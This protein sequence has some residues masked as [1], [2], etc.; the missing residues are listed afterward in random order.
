[1]AGLL[2]EA[3]GLGE[4]VGDDVG[5]GLVVGEAPQ[6]GVVGDGSEAEGVAEAVGEL[7][8]LLRRA[9]VEAEVLLEQKAGQ[10]RLLGLLEAYPR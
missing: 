2:E 3:D 1:M 9:V 4:R 8:R 7:Q 6:R 10:Q 5:G